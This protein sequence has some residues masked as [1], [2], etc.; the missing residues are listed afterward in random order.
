MVEEP[1]KKLV[2]RK[3]PSFRPII[4][5]I[6]SIIFQPPEEEKVEFVNKMVLTN[7]KKSSYLI[8]NEAIGNNVEV[9]NNLNVIEEEK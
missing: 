9:V 3:N 5:E 8:P 4:E 7:K 2:K 6:N 1:I